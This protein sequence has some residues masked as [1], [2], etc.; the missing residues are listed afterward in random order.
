MTCTRYR[1]KM[2]QGLVIDYT[3]GNKHLPE[4]LVVLMQCRPATEKKNSLARSELSIERSHAARNSHT[5]LV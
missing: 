2:K 5:A 3:E 1:R 4:S